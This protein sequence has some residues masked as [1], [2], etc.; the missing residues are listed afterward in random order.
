VIARV[1]ADTYDADRT[2]AP[3]GI[4]RQRLDAHASNSSIRKRDIPE[5]QTG[6]TRTVAADTKAA[7]EGDN[8]ADTVS[9]SGLTNYEAC[10][11]LIP[12]RLSSVV[13]KIKILENQ[14]MVPIYRA[15]MKRIVS[16]LSHKHVLLHACGH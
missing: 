1:A 12:C 3:I 9:L 15:T 11:A 7:V 16:I 14:A 10:V 6:R 5:P 8:V 4:S 13:L 2:P